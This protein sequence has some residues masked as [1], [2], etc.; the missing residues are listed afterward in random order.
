LLKH[1]DIDNIFLEHYIY[2][3]EG[4]IIIMKFIYVLLAFFVLGTLF[5]SGCV[6]SNQST[7]SDNNLLISDSNVIMINHFV[8][9]P[10]EL[11]VA[12]GT[13]VKWIQNDNVTHIVVSNGLF[14]SKPLTKGDEFSFTFNT[15]GKYN[16]YCSIHTS[17]TGKIIVK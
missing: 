11:I 4:F 15:P 10:N 13:T 17:M 3:G 2:K 16:Y 7:L 9:A 14:E 8:F 12:K 5:I 6:Q 1:T